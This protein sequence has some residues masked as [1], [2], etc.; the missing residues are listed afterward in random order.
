[1]LPSFVGQSSIPVQAV[2]RAGLSSVPFAS[3]LVNPVPLGV[4]LAAFQA[5]NAFDLYDQSI[6]L[7]SY[8]VSGYRPFLHL[9][10]ASNSGTSYQAAT[11]F[12]SLATDEQ[13]WSDGLHNS[14]QLGTGNTVALANG[15]FESQVRAGLLDN[16]RRQA[17]T[18]ASGNTYALV[19]VPLWSQYQTGGAVDTVTIA[20]F[21]RFK[22][23]QS[24]IT[25][26]TLRGYFVPYPVT[27]P[28][29]G[30]APGLRWGPERIAFLL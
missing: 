15:S 6:A 18:D 12:G 5:G 11:D 27:N 25:T 4:P 16:V 20:G 8:G 22:I 1:M 29:S 24:D 14:G 13:F 19:D 10:H 23:L 28:P 17:L 2:A 21:A 7:A 30:S 26:T 3:T 9:A